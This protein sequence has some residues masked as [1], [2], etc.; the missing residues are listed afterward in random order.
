MYILC[1]PRKIFLFFNPTIVALI[2]LQKIISQNCVIL[3]KY[4]IRIKSEYQELVP[5]YNL[6]NLI[7]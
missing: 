5:S 2:I 7:L 4:I 6:I 1:T 3:F